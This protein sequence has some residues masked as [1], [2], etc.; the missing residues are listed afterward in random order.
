MNASQIEL[1]PGAGNYGGQLLQSGVVDQQRIC[2]FQEYEYSVKSA[3][4][5]ENEKIVMKGARTNNLKNI[6]VSIPLQKMICVIG[7]SGSGKSSLVSK[8]LYPAIVMN[9]RISDNHNYFIYGDKPFFW[10]GDT[11]AKLLTML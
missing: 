6:D 11:M 5:E 3:V 8:T 9:L 2:D 7:V 4:I 10:L 1:G